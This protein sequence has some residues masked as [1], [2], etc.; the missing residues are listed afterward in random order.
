MDFWDPTIAAIMAVGS[1][2]TA[3]QQQAL[4]PIFRSLADKYELKG[5]IIASHY[6]HALAGDE[7]PTMPTRPKLVVDNT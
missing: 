2:L 4:V 1:V 3:E 6:L 7:P 5:E